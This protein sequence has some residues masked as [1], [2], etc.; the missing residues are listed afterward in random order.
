MTTIIKKLSLRIALEC[1]V[2]GLLFAGSAAAQTITGSIGGIVKDSSGAV[3]PGVKVTV[4]DKSTNVSVSTQT[5]GAGVYEV[6]FLTSSTFRVTFAKEGFKTYLEENVPVI[7]NQAVHLDVVLVIGNTTQ[8]VTVTAE[9]PQVN[10]DSGVVAGSLANADLMKFPEM[11][12]GHGPNELTYVKI[13]PGMSGSSPSFSNT[14]NFSIGGGRADSTPII[15]DGLPSNMAVDNTYG[16]TPTPDSTAELQVLITPYSAQYGQ[17]GGGAILTTTK[18]GTNNLHGSLFEYHN[19]QNLNAVDYFTNSSP[20]PRPVRARTI[21]NYFGGSA[22]GPVYIPHL[23]NGR[24]RHTFFFSDLEDTLSIKPGTLNTQVPTAMEK[25]GNFSGLSPSNTTTPTIYD[26]ATTVVSGSTVTRTAYAGNIIT[27]PE[28]PVAKAIMSY[29]PA[30]NCTNGSFDYCVTPVSYRSYLFSNTRVDQEIGDY[31][32]LWAR[33]SRD[34]PWTEGVPYINNAANTSLTNGWR[35]YHEE[36]S[37]VH[38]FSPNVTNEFRLGQ[39]EEDNFTLA[40]AQD[41]ATLGLP[42][43]PANSE[44]PGMTVTG[45]YTIGGASPSNSLDRFQIFN[46]GLQIQKGKHSFRVGGEFTRYM[47]NQ[48]SPGVLAGGYSFT[49]TFTSTTISGKSSGGF[50]LADLY[51]GDVAT[52]SLSTNNYE[53]RYRL[54]YSAVYIQDDYKI[55]PKLTLNL[56]LRWEFDGP[57]TEVNN[58]IYSMNPTMTDPT[59]GKLGAVQFAGRNGA[60]RHFLANDFRGFLPRAGFAYSLNHNTV[61]RGGGGLFELPSIGYMTTGSTNEYSKSCSF[62]GVNSY[63]PAFQLNAGQ[64]A[65]AFNQN[66]AGLPNLVSS[67]TSPTQSLTEFQTQ[68]KIPLLQEWSLSVQHQFGNGWVG[69]I[70]YIG[71]KGT[72]EPVQLAMNQIYPIAG[73]CY[74]QTSPT[75]QSLRPYPQWNNVTYFSL[76]GNSNYN[77]LALTLQHYWSH[78][79]STL[80]AYTYAKTMDDVDGINKSDGVGNQ[81]TYNIASQYGVAMIDLPQ[82]FSASYVW[83]VPIGSGG[84]L[85]QNVPVVNAILGHWEFG[86]VT[87]FQPGYPYNVSQTNTDGLFNSAQYTSRTGEVIHPSTPTVAQWFNPL[88][89]TPTAQDAFGTTPRASLFGPGLNNWDLSVSRNF[90]IREKFTLQFRGD[91]SNLFNHLQLDNLNTACTTIVSGQCGGA[92]GAATGDVGARSIQ[93][94]AR[95]TF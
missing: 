2:V 27:E 36:V 34:G 6:P 88:A 20:G 55:T 78:G 80:L 39:V 84:K 24:N 12:G 51:L 56:G 82:R 21:V 4:T 8:S 33:Y 67:L 43:V 31:D 57:T 86:G 18:S 47:F 93:L 85:A 40:N 5:N 65:C 83:L 9:P 71:N 29:Y 13:F 14:N 73:C 87:Q 72:H 79:L 66:S 11:I 50:G 64:P 62:K 49:G 44:F 1:L 3:V 91:F 25:Q 53:F 30:P 22:G 81:N 74:G 26:P 23:W 92:F 75:P 95:L 41:T 35:D 17:T 76:S 90:P 63:T 15:E 48:Y 94:N 89:F 58:W 46:D 60:P 68:P 77:A 28:D 59:T 37:W 70:S 16:F 61:I 19:D 38:I 42:G 54:N 69:E 32:R 10:T 52:S 45:L 7:L